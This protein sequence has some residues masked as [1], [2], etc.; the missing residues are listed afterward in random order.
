MYD[1]RPMRDQR[2]DK[3]TIPGNTMYFFSR[4]KL[5]PEVLNCQI[6]NA[7]LSRTTNTLSTR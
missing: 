4:P 2:S 7:V 3:N 6:L 1:P 5:E